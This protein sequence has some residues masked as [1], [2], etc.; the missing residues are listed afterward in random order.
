MELGMMG[1]ISIVDMWV[2]LCVL[3]WVWLWVLAL[4][5]GSVT[6]RL[7]RRT[8]AEIEMTVAIL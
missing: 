2:Y 5:P 1:E 4:E 7:W 6:R 8:S 3:W